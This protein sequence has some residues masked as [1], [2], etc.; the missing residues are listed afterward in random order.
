MID[1]LANL[2]EA[3]ARRLEERAAQW[4]VKHPEEAKLIREEV[5]VRFRRANRPDPEPG[6]IQWLMI[7]AAIV[8]AIRAKKGW[9]TQ[10]EYEQLQAGQEPTPKAPIRPAVSTVDHKALAG[11][12]R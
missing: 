2:G 10:R 1:V 4:S 5:S 6:S 3:Y 9:P 7:E 8:D 12:D 11:G